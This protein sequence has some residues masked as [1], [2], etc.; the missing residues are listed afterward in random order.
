MSP[1]G[2]TPLRGVVNLSAV[3]SSLI[4]TLYDFDKRK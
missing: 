1:K 3:N 4:Y 2:I